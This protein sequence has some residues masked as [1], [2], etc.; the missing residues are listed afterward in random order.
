[1]TRRPYKDMAAYY[2]CVHKGCDCKA[3]SE[4]EIDEALIE[5]IT[6]QYNRYRIMLENNDAVTNDN[7]GEEIKKAALTE[8]EKL[9]KQQHKLY[10]LLEQEVYTTETFVERSSILSKRIKE[11]E[12]IIESQKSE[13]KISVTA[14]EACMILKNILD[15]YGKITDAEKRNALL[16]TAVKRINYCKT[17]GGRYGKSDMTLHVDYIF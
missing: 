6:K 2:M 10:D 12:K 7:S 1:M 17:T 9:K 16:K 5:S 11:L 15:D 14:Q 13:T 3:S 4:I 8:L